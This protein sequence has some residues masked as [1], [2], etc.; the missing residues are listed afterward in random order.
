MVTFAAVEV[1]VRAKVWPAT[2]ASVPKVLMLTWVGVPW[3][4][5]TKS[6]AAFFI[7]VS[8]VPSIDAERSKM[9]CTLMPHTAGI[10]G[11]WRRVTKGLVVRSTSSSRP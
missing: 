5:E 4:L 6:F 11:S 10:P 1:D 3:R 2:G 8:S 7:V 9:S